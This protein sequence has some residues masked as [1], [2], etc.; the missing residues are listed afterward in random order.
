MGPA[1]LYLTVCHK[2]ITHPWMVREMVSDYIGLYLTTFTISNQPRVHKPEVQH[3][4]EKKSGVLPQ[5]LTKKT[6]P[7]KNNKKNIAMLNSQRP[8]VSSLQRFL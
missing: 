1:F 2:Q 7:N 6:N 5:K 4:T 8:K 3:G